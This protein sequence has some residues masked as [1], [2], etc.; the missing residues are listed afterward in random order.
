MASKY[1][2]CVCS[3]FV[4]SVLLF[5]PLEFTVTESCTTNVLL[6]RNSVAEAVSSHSLKINCT[7]KYCHTKPLIKWCK[8]AD[9][10]V[11]QPVNETDQTEIMWGNMEGTSDMLFLHFKYITV[12]D[13]GLYRCMCENTSEGCMSH[14][15]HVTVREQIVDNNQ[16]V[17]SVNQTTNASVPETPDTPGWYWPAIYISSGIT[18]VVIVTVLSCLGLRCCQG[19]RQAETKK[20]AENQYA[21]VQMSDVSPPFPGLRHPLPN[22]PRPRSNPTPAGTPGEC[23][24][25]NGNDPRSRATSNA[26]S[27]R[28]TVPP[29]DA[30]PSQLHST[31][32][33]ATPNRTADEEASPLVY[34]SLNHQAV[35]RP[36]ARPIK[37]T[38]ST[39]YAAIRL[40]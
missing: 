20:A 5:M 12:N 21:S 33:V 28:D 30:V 29:R 8:V 35:S 24:Y 39:E 14:T 25:E 11:C 40:S 31:N 13:S 2:S 6:K 34:A 15:V 7:V 3:C 36:H 19:S 26:S 37:V 22:K 1:I 9:S 18:F 27:L 10:N 4:V 38:E 16:T 32:R 17:R 23:V